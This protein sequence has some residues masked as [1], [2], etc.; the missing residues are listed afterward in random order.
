[1]G[2]ASART[3]VLVEHMSVVESLLHLGV[4]IALAALVGV[5]AVAVVERLAGT[6][7]PI[8]K[9]PHVLIAAAVLVVFIVADVLHDL[10][11]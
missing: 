10:I 11:A 1:V 7:T 2:K 5:G 4:F 3:L 9:R 8:V 6:S